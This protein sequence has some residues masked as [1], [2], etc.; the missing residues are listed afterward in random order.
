[1][2]TPKSSR[3]RWVLLGGAFGAGISAV[4]VAALGVFAGAGAAAPQAAPQNIDPPKISGTPQENH[5]LTG[6][7]GTWS[8]N[9]TDYNYSW[10]RCNK[11]GASCANISGAHAATYKL[12]SADVGTT[13][14]FKVQAK[15]ADGNS[16][17]S[18][19]PTA[20][21]T[22]A[23]KQPPPPSPPPPPATGCPSGSGPA[24]VTAISLP[25]RLII[26]QQQSD[27]AVVTPSTQQVVLRYHV[28][29]TCSQAVQGALVYATAVPF[30]QL[31]VPGEQPTGSDGWAVLTFH[32]LSGFPV[33]THQQL[34][35]LF[36]RAR[37]QGE[38]PLAGIST[39][40]L[41]SLRVNLHG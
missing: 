9:P 15:N 41:F 30:G 37:K 16:S 34:I 13:I 10:T 40:R 29:D 22:A 1:M 36:V 20:V 39:R 4:L 21:I 5:T 7:K 19:V 14:R 32:T 3:K 26:D 28:T 24:P 12:T 33:S 23:N 25:A 6:E 17:A 31:S 11:T 38:N 18:S 8:G 35:A 2:P 27:P